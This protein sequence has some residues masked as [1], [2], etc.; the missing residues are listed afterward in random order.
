MRNELQLGQHKVMLTLGLRLV[1]LG[2]LLL[3]NE[4]KSFEHFIG[5]YSA[6]YLPLP[7]LCVQN[8]EEYN[9]IKMEDNFDVQSELT[10]NC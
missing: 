3:Q 4:Q 7:D 1:I 8:I 9:S 2:K 10:G 6:L 5:L